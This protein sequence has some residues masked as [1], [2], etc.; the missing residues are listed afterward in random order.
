MLNADLPV[1]ATSRPAVLL[2]VPDH[3]TTLHESAG[4]LPGGIQSPA[5][6]IRRHGTRLNSIGSLYCLLY[7]LPVARFR[8][9]IP[10]SLAYPCI[11]Q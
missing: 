9:P 5:G 10:G 2:Q 6:N 7:S 11:T 3:L 4:H 8:N 1:V